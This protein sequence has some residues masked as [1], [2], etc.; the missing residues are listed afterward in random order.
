LPIEAGMGKYEAG[1]SGQGEQ[2]WGGVIR[3]KKP[4]GEFDFY[5]FESTYMVAAPAAAVSAD[6]MNVFYIGVENPVSVS[7]AGVSPTELQVSGSGSGI[8]LTPK[9]AGKYIVKVSAIGEATI[10]VSAKTKDGTKP[11]G[12]QK[13]RCK[14]IPTPYASFAGKKSGDKATKGELSAANFIIA[15]LDGFDFA[16][17]FQVVSWEF[18]GQVSGKVVACSG[19]GGSVSSELRGY[20]GKVGPGSKL[21]FDVKAKGPDGM[22]QVLPTLGIKVQ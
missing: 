7:A 8:T 10:N 19:T 1:A 18:V 15:K 21:F 20:L 5:P 3:F 14:R 22:V 13:F 16:A 6:A 9:G 4:T 17:N 11:Q 2:K 12:S